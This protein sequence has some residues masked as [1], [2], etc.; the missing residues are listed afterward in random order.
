M[1]NTSAFNF[2]TSCSLRERGFFQDPY[3][4]FPRAITCWDSLEHIPDPKALVERVE[5]AVF[6]SLPVFNDPLAATRSKHYRPGEHIWYWSE[7]GLE[8]WFNEMGFDLAEKNDDE[9]RIGRE[10]IMSFAFLRRGKKPS[11][12][13]K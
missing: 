11:L 8:K 9:T 12:D 13:K 2:V 4:T 6:V 1:F 7:R 10:G 3:K 5:E